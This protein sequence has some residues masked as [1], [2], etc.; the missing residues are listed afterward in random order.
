MTLPDYYDRLSATRSVAQFQSE[1][2][3]CA[4]EVGKV[5]DAFYYFY[6]SD[7]NALTR[8]GEVLE[9]DQRSLPGKCALLREQAREDETL[10]VPVRHFGQL[11][12]VLMVIA[13]ENTEMPS[14]VHDLLRVVG[15]VQEH[16][17]IGEESRIYTERSRDLMVQ[18]V[19]AL[20]S[21]ADHVKRVAR[22]C[23]ELAKL[24]DL[25]VQLKY[26][27]FQAAQYHDVG[28]LAL[29]SKSIDDAQRAHATAGAEFLRS[30]RNL[31]HL[32]PFVE[33]HHERYDG[34]G[35]PKGHAGD[36]LPIDCW[37]MPLAEHLD[38]FWQRSPHTDYRDKL[39]AFFQTEVA[40][41]H[42]EVV[43][44][45]CGLADSGRLEEILH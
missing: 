29:Q 11:V 5:D 35:F 30:A 3:R 10:C 34:T 32:A 28:L 1:V 19:E 4:S 36:D 20:G 39:K 24:L 44:A 33:A 16:V 7:A 12:G 27:L 23:T 17:V 26:D 15:Q 22:L 8:Q 18:A 41:H 25:S 43:D 13:D 21:G 9:M 14:E 38:E 45:L 2:E 37:V 6:S 31:R 40:H 42:P